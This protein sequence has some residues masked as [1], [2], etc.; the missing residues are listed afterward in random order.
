MVEKYKKGIFVYVLINCFALVVN[1]FNVYV[2]T[3]S[4]PSYTFHY[5]TRYNFF[6]KNGLW[7]FVNFTYQTNKGYSSES[8]GF[9]GI[10][11]QYHWREFILYIGLLVAFL[12]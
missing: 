11:Y 5:F 2:F 4:N 9:N 10:F 6:D 7:P 3:S 12:I 8:N 1:L